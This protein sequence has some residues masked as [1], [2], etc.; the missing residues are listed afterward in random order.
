MA[1]RYAVAT[2]NW[3]DN[4]TWSATSG[5]AAGASFPTSTDNAYFDA[6][7]GA[8]TVTVNVASAC[9]GLLMN[10]S[11]GASA[12]TGTFAGSSALAVYDNVSVSG[13]MTWT[14][15]GTMSLSATSG[16][17]TFASNAKALAARCTFVNT[18]ATY[19]L[20]DALTTTAQIDVSGGTFATGGFAVSCLDLN[21]SGTP[22][23]NL[24][25]SAIT[26]T[27]RV[28]GNTGATMN[29]GTSVITVSGDDFAGAG[30]TYATVILTGV[31][32][33][34]LTGANTFTTLTRTNA[35]GYA[36]LTLGANQT[37]T[38]T[39][40]VTGNNASTQRIYVA[41]DTV[42]T[43]RTITAA[44]VAL[45]NV[46]FEDVT[47]AGAASPFTGTL[48]G[49]CGGNTNI[50]Q[51]TPI[52]CYWV[53]AGADSRIITDALW[54]TTSGGAV[55]A[56]FPLAQDTAV[57]DASSFGAASKVITIGVAGLRIGTINWTGATNT[58]TLSLDAALN[59]YGSL[60][61]ITAITF[62]GASLPTFKGRGSYTLTNSGRTFP[63]SLTVD[64]FGG[65]LTLQDA[66][67]VT[68]ALTLTRGTL[69][70]NNFA[71]TASTFSSAGTSTRTL[72]MGTATW[73]VSGTTTVWDTSTTTG[74]TLNA[75]TST[76]AITNASA[77][78]KTFAGGGLAYSSLTLSGAGSGAYTISGASTSFTG[79]TTVSNTGSAS[80]DL[81]GSATVTH[82][83]VT[84]AGATVTWAG[85]TAGTISGSLTLA[86]GVT[87]SHTGGLTFSATSS[88]TITNADKTFGEAL[89]FDGVAGTWTMQDAFICSAAVTLTNGTLAFS[90]FAAT[91][92]SLSSSNANT[93]TI[94]GSGTITITTTAATTGWDCATSTNLTLSLS[95]STIKIT[96]STT[97]VRTFAGGGKTY[98]TLWFSNATSA[99]TLRISGSNT[100][101]TLKCD[102]PPQTMAFATGTTQ[103]ITTWSVNGT[104]GN[105]ITL[106]EY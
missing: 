62:S 96:G 94:S 22:T 31:T 78:Q 32:T 83:T 43:A 13:S 76:V 47:A 55:A 85:S 71:V 27:R 6:A 8:V 67:I 54:F 102:T 25:A 17:K 14:Y 105:L 7:S 73:T 39:F 106:A 66:A 58:P 91:M 35:S 88:V 70:A 77:T 52:S 100:F 16:S 45:T 81:F 103:T 75:S 61:L 87:V 42:G 82:K 2:G 56:R 33:C 72:N 95:S 4:N 48:I 15:S 60:T 89:T 92:L 79:T 98:G 57:F 36:S 38:G 21:W 40:T 64:A 104:S 9:L 97:N 46:D 65:T 93:R 41:S 3:N 80:V 99:G 20:S 12:F 50:T 30:L 101:G 37:V 59:I 53:H 49:N 74:L 90:T 51:T 10:G 68:T 84:F 19:T 5:G 24:G 26:V 63:G 23:L 11:G 34:A 18:G 86:A 28:N 44:V 29:A 1:D 69:T